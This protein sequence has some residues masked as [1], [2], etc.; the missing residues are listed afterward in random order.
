[1]ALRRGHLRPPGTSLYVDG[2]A[3][4]GEPLDQHGR[5]LRGDSTWDFAETPSSAAT[6]PDYAPTRFHGELSRLALFDNALAPDRLQAVLNAKQVGPRCSAEAPR[7]APST[8]A[9]TTDT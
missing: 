8:P 1:M 3:G 5:R 2:Q 4:G 7:P 6:L 9:L